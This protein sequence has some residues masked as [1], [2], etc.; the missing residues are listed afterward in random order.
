MTSTLVSELKS[1]DLLDELVILAEEAVVA[2]FPEIA[3]E[4]LA[5][6]NSHQGKMTISTG[7]E[8]E[9]LPTAF[10]DLSSSLAISSF[11]CLARDPA[12]EDL[13]TTGLVCIHK[14]MC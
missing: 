8:P 5:I 9:A 1:E 10:P 2:A 12:A 3:E 11:A 6:P 7:E 14:L 4:T 13:F